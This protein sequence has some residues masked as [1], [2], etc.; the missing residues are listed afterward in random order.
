VIFKPAG[1]ATH[2]APGHDDDL[3]SRVA[4][5]LALRHAPY[6]AAPVHRLDIGT[7]G[8]L[9]FGKG[10]QAIASFG[11]LLMD[12]RIHK[13]YL[14][15]VAGATPPCGELTSEV[16]DG[17]VMRRALTRYRRLAS[18]GGLTLLELDLVT[19]RPHQ[20]RRQLADAGWP[21]VGD[22]RYGGTGWP[23]LQYPFLH[24]HRLSF[25]TLD[26]GEERQVTWPLPESLTRFLTAAGVT[27]AVPTDGSSLIY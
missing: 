24:S 22:R 26:T 2:R 11:Q 20:A 21:I 7:S 18:G 10:R 5:F 13:H 1:L 15:L 14:A 16:P 27:G 9:L 6:R 3:N 19:G 12:G 25:P 23:G 4:H 8:P 17:A